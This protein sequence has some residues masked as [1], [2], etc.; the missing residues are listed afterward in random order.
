MTVSEEVLR[1]MPAVGEPAAGI[2]M[3]CSISSQET[4]DKILT[5]TGESRHG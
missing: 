4:N 3:P 5:Y 1:F 2:F